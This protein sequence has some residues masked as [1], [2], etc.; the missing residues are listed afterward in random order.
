MNLINKFVFS[1]FVLITAFTLTAQ[2]ATYVVTNTDNNGPGSLREAIDAANSTGDDDTINFEIPGCANGGCTING[3]IFSVGAAGKL[4]IANKPNA[5]NIALDANGLGR[6]MVVNGGANL[7]LSGLT[8]T[9][10]NCLQTAQAPFE[11]GSGIY[12]LGGSVTL[13]KSAVASNAGVSS[14][15]APGAGGITNQGNLTLIDS[16]VSGNGGYTGGI[17][18]IGTTVITNSSVSGNSGNGIMCDGGFITVNGSQINGNGS[19]IFN[20]Y[21]TIAITETTISGNTTVDANNITNYA[22]LTLTSSTV[23]DNAQGIYNNNLQE[24][25]GLQLKVVNSVIERNGNSK[26]TYAGI[27]SQGSDLTDLVII[28]STFSNNTGIFAGGICVTNGSLTAINSTITKNIGSG[29]IVGGLL[30]FGSAQGS[31]LNTIVA[32]NITLGESPDVSN[33]GSLISKGNNLITNSKSSGVAWLPS[34]I[35]DQSPRFG[36]LGNYGG[37]TLTFAL[38]NN[39]PAINA[40]NSCV[41]TL[42]GCGD[43]NPA[44][45]FDQ[46]GAA[47]VG[48]VDIGA[49][50]LNNTANGGTFRAV[51]TEGTR[52]KPYNY[53]ITPES[54]AFTYSV[55]GGSLPLG[56]SL[57]NSARPAA[58]NALVPAA[59]PYSITGTPTMGGT[60]NYTITATDGTNSFN[61][62]YT[63]NII[64]PPPT[65]ASVNVGGR[66]IALGRGLANARVVLADQNGQARTALSNAFGYYEFE[67]ALAG[68]TYII[69]ISSKRYQFAPQLVSVTDEIT[70]LVFSAE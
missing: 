4:T 8:L 33:S 69:S 25:P 38:T 70:D 53:Q 27:L 52:N 28:N 63:T 35:L 54:G 11:C 14:E 19:A 50:E 5:G 10:G 22:T 56:L 32:E 51:T 49:F 45:A 34:D 66:V 64:V 2:A 21:G 12:N 6:V 9:G 17:Y 13:I 46:R 26:Y 42:N 15:A 48:A 37:P 47:R 61:T 3:A 59:G 41:I 18:N 43:G 24:I 16:T 55:T 68:E 20:N 57:T 30:V 29:Q 23:K 7:I 65:A 44:L 40:G 39:S 36:P 62:D 67:N 1:I 31:L 60:F 58:K